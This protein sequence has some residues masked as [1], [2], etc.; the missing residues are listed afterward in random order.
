MHLLLCDIHVKAC[1]GDLII[2]SSIILRTTL[3]L[4]VRNVRYV[5]SSGPTFSLGLHTYS[6]KN[7]TK[8]NLKCTLRIFQKSGKPSG[9]GESTMSQ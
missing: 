6:I 3:D 8:P 2:C 7:L 5:S 4:K 1:L 9:V